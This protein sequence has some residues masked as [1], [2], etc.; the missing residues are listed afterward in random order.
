ML[1]DPQGSNA[2]GNRMAQFVRH[3]DCSDDQDRLL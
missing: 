2:N 1:S 3:R